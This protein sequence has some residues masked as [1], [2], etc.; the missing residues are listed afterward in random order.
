MFILK[1]HSR[2]MISQKQCSSKHF[3]I[4][5]NKTYVYIIYSEKKFT[6]KKDIGR[7]DQI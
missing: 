5:M 3:L 4:E 7:R 6:F 1:T 2:Y